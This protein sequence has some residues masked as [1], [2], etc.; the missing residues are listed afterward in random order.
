L[1]E[2]EAERCSREMILQVDVKRGGHEVVLS[3][4]HHTETFAGGRA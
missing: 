4:R 3:R 1:N 2:L